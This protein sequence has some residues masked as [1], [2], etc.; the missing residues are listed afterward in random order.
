MSLGRADGHEN[1]NLWQLKWKTLF[2]VEPE[3][4]GNSK[5]KL[6]IIGRTNYMHNREIFL[7]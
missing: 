4:E 1:F 5:R 6:A 3:N 2:F 7:E